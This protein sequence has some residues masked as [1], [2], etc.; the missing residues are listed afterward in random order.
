MKNAGLFSTL[1]LE[2]VSRQVSCADDAQG[3]FVTLGQSWLQRDASSAATLWSSFIKAA[4][5]NLGF[6]TQDHPMARGFHPLY[7]DYGFQTAS[8]CSI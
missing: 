6:V 1:F 7:E 5:G 8:A 2:T 3:R 4:L